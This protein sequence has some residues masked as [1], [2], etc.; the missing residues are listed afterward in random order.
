[1]IDSTHSLYKLM[2]L[3]LLDRAGFPM[4]NTAISDFMVGNR[5]TEFFGLQGIFTEMVSSGLLS[6]R[7]EPHTTYYEITDEGRETL[8]F[9]DNDISPEIRRDMDDY[10]KKNGFALRSASAVTVRYR[11]TSE[12]GYE[13]LCTASDGR[14]DLIRM[15]LFADT[16]ESAIRMCD[17]WKKKSA[18]L[19]AV[20]MKELL[21]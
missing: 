4:T 14:D 20:L 8:S 19:Y 11:W 1:M 10:L 16:E 5:Y 9:F 18:D 2:V 13:V 7:H 17:N 21:E 12:N 3:Y 6:E 15:T